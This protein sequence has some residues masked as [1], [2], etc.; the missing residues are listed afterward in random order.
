MRRQPRTK[1]A[2]GTSRQKLIAGDWVAAYHA[3]FG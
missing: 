1:S 3:R 2:P